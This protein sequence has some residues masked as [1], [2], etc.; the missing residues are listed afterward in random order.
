MRV[1]LAAAAA[2]LLFAPAAG[3][4]VV[5]QESI[6]GVKI[7][8]TAAQ[9]RAQLGKPKKVGYRP[10]Q[11]Q[12]SIKVYDY[13]LTDV[14]L[15]RGAEGQVFHVVTTSRKQRTKEGLGVGSTRAAIK[16]GYSKARCF[17]RICAIGDAP[18]GEAVTTF[19][20]T[21]AGKVRMISLATLND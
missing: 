8:M 19:Y 6:A 20:F 21:A 7:G 15:S 2:L 5:V 10:D 13:G 14:Y 4:T 9:V 16:R 3:S 18:A 17:E 1:L 12:G 11:I